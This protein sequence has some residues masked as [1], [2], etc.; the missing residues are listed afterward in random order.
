MN[1]VTVG[2]HALL[3][4]IDSEDDQYIDRRVTVHD[5][6]LFKYSRSLSLIVDGS[7]ELSSEKEVSLC[8]KVI[9]ESSSDEK[10]RASWYYHNTP[11]LSII[12]GMKRP[13]CGLA[14][15]LMCKDV[16]QLPSNSRLSVGTLLKAAKQTGITKQ[17][18][19]FAVADMCRLAASTYNC[20]TQVI[21]GTLVENCHILLQHLLQNQHAVMIAYDSDRNF[22]P[23]VKH[24][25]TAHWAIITGFLIGSDISPPDG[26]NKVTSAEVANNLRR[27]QADRG[28]CITNDVNPNQVFL[29]AKQA[30]SAKI[31]LWPL[32]SLS[33]SN[34]AIRERSPSRDWKQYQCPYD[35]KKSL[36][37][38]FIVL[39]PHNQ[40]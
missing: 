24:G 33:K 12:Q 15:L 26:F 13:V 16:L 1:N 30:K 18:E 5:C 37:N 34:A 28:C 2:N 39:S 36:S 23:C 11:V 14:A 10:Q 40:Y 17:G 27:I 31:C 35:L 20:T 7:K 8:S 4:E 6:S 32:T 21:H 29:F 9:C 19:I 22:S 38:Q 3:D 25:H